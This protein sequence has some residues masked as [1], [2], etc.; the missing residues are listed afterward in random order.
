MQPN[1]IINREIPSA[2]IARRAD[3]AL[4]HSFYSPLFPDLHSRFTAPDG[5]VW[6]VARPL[7]GDIRPGHLFAVR[8]GG[9]PGHGYSYR[10]FPLADCAPYGGAAQRPAAAQRECA[11]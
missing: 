1:P 4:H 7:N 5:T 11:A 3:D 10:W 2:D 9:L 6:Q 8:G